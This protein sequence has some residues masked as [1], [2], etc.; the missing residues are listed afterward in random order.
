MRIGLFSDTYPPF[1]NGVS[2]SVL[3][4]KKG[5]EEMG[6]DV[7]VV[8]PNDEAFKYKIEDNEKVL[9]VPG[10]PIGI[11]DY[12]IAGVYSLKALKIIKEWK[13]DIIHSHTEFGVG[14]FARF[15]SNQLNIPLVHT[16]HTMY[17][18]YVHYITRGYFNTAS[19]KL[20]KYLSLFYVDKTAN[21]LIVPTEKTKEL[22][23]EKYSY[24]KELFVI[25]TGIEIYRFYKENIDE[26]R[27][28][29][30]KEELDIKK[31]DFVIVYIGR[32][33]KEK[34]IDFLIESHQV[35]IK[36]IK[37][38]KLVIVGDGPDLPGFIKK[39]QNENIDNIIFTG[40]VPWTE[41]PYY[42]HLGNVFATA[43]TSETQGLTVIE[44]MASG[45]VPVAIDDDSFKNSINSGKD[46][47]I[48]NN[49]EDYIKNII[50]LS[51]NPNSLNKLSEESVKSSQKFSHKFYAQEVIKVYEKVISENQSFFDKYI[52]NL[53][54]GG[55]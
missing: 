33:A 27:L 12:R 38:I 23:T 2:T 26:K 54:K 53:K 11:Y 41:T 6:H 34:S 7:Y 8:T 21:A 19:K 15:I 48:F 31:D 25:P 52:D 10:M 22:F 28:N 13:L 40:K 39:V 42:Y 5:L 35:L 45:T 55:K 3:M 4:L 30:L 24:K 16:Y 37:N 44:A 32:I 43:S 49:R 51:S 36:T 47:I 18:D 14:I 50:Y 29:N 20:V 9:R 46:G 17:E 1:I